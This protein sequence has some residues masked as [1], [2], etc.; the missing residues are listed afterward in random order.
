MNK[1][2]KGDPGKQGG[3]ND[4]EEVKEQNKVKESWRCVLTEYGER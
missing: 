1:G 2:E 4:G 3:G